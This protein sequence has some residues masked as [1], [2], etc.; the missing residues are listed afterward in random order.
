MFGQGTITS[1]KNI[2]SSC[3]F[4]DNLIDKHNIAGK[5]SSCTS[6]NSQANEGGNA[7]TSNTDDTSAAGVFSA[8]SLV[9]LAVATMGAFFL[10]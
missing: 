7:G 4:F 9:A 1:T 8:N 6:S 10:L 3:V 2:S 5:D